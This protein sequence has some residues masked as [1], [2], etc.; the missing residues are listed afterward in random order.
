MKEFYKKK[1]K[2]AYAPNSYSEAISKTP[3]TESAETSQ[4]IS[5]NSFSFNEITSALKD[6][7]PSARALSESFLDLQPKSPDIINQ[8][9]MLPVQ[10]LSVCFHFKHNKDPTLPLI[11]GYSYGR[12]SLPPRGYRFYRLKHVSQQA[13]FSWDDIQYK[14]VYSAGKSTQVD[15]F[16]SNNGVN[17]MFSFKL[18]PPPV[19]NLLQ[20]RNESPLPNSVTDDEVDSIS[21][22]ASSSLSKMS[23]NRGRGRGRGKG[24]PNAPGSVKDCESECKGR[25]R[26]RGS[27]PTDNGKV[28][29][30]D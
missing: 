10:A 12:G 13:D 6:T 25:G 26:G 15:Q 4:D 3:V 1:A 24:V 11:P 19:N 27:I 20:V 5:K 2:E 21:S 9:D 28:G 23:K 17:T 29:S 8:P 18:R 30:A 16:V 7:L 14:K 22:Y